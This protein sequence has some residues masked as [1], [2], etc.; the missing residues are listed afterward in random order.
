MSGPLG[1]ARQRCP[2]W[3]QR[4]AALAATDWTRARTGNR[5]WARPPSSAPPWRRGPSRHDAVDR[6]MLPPG[7]SPVQDHRAPALPAE[8]RRPRRASGSPRCTG[9]STGVMGARRRFGAW[10]PW[11]G[12]PGA[13]RL[14]GPPHCPV[15][16]VGTAGRADGDRLIRVPL[17]STGGT[18][19]RGPPERRPTRAKSLDSGH[20][21]R[22]CGRYGRGTAVSRTGAAEDGGAFHA[23]ALG[24]RLAAAS[25]PSGACGARGLRRGRSRAPQ[26]RQSNGR[27]SVARGCRGDPEIGVS[28]ERLLPQPQLDR[29]DSAP[30]P[31]GVAKQWR[32]FRARNKR[33]SFATHLLQRGTHILQ[34]GGQGVPSPLDDLDG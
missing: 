11:K 14:S 21:L 4:R 2:A 25:G 28:I 13:L 31:A 19:C 27:R 9:G 34:Q 16:Q 22:L 20:H 24:W 12:A 33:H 3:L 10:G 23:G 29:P 1:G 17:D 6:A 30:R 5:Q 15:V 18:G 8:G 26:G 32:L 7:L